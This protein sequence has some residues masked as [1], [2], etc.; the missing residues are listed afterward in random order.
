M[1]VESQG[2]LVRRPGEGPAVHE[3]RLGVDVSFKAVSEDTSGKYACYEYVAPA[4]FGGPP[5]HSHPSFDEAWYVLEGE[6]TLVVGE[7]TITAGVGTFVHVP[8]AAPH[9]FANRGG[10]PVRFLGL[11]V[12]GGFERYFGEVGGIVAQ[13]GFPPPAEVLQEL[14]RRYGLIWSPA[15]AGSAD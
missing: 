12:P 1:T 4:G 3:P 14:S 10:A 15:P 8:G 9:T 11:I 7:E 2:V 5:R 6:L 13:H